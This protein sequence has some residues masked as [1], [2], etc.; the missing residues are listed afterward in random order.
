MRSSALVCDLFKRHGIGLVTLQP[1]FTL[2]S[3]LGKTGRIYVSCQYQ[4]TLLEGNLDYVVS[5]VSTVSQQVRKKRKSRYQNLPTWH[6]RAPARRIATRLGAVDP[7][8]SRPSRVSSLTQSVPAKTLQNES[9]TIENAFC[10][11][12]K[13]CI[14]D[15]NLNKSCSSFTTKTKLWLD[16]HSSKVNVFFGIPHYL[17]VLARVQKEMTGFLIKLVMISR[18][19][20][21]PRRKCLM[22][23]NKRPARRDAVLYHYAASLIAI[24]VVNYS[25]KCYLTEPTDNGVIVNHTIKIVL[26]L[27]Q[28]LCTTKCVT[29]ERQ[30]R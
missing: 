24:L 22:N 15:V 11:L 20:A 17:V 2:A 16:G 13:K 25:E 18:R 5:N 29:L 19:A 14:L 12:K 7:P 3:D 6:A 30:T 8:E 28:P 27:N 23:K 9:R 1:E 10:S 21:P 4:V 26:Y